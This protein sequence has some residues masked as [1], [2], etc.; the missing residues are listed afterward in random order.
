MDV[1]IVVPASCIVE[2]VWHVGDAS[3]DDDDADDDEQ[4]DE[5]NAEAVIESSD[6]EV[7]PVSQ[8]SVSPMIE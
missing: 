6:D 2:V 8:R 7:E 5:V 3:D 4:C 1:G